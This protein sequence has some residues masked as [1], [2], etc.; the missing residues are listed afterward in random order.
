LVSVT[1]KL[2]FAADVVEKIHTTHVK[3]T[4]LPVD[5]EDPVRSELTTGRTKNLMVTG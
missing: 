5:S 2:I 1:K 3:S 4:A